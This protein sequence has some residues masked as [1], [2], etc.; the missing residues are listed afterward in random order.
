[1]TI[2]IIRSP[3]LQSIPHGF[4]GRKGGVSTGVYHGLNTGPGSGDDPAAVTENRNRAVAAIAPD[5]Q[6]ITLYQIHSATAIVVDA[7]FEDEARPQGDAMVTNKPGLLLG[8]LTADCTPI[9][10]ADTQNAVIGAAHAG[11]KG[12]IG[13]IITATLDAMESLGAKRENICAAI[14]PTI[15]KSSYEVNDQFR[16]RFL[17]QSPTNERFFTDGKSGHA[18]F[19]LEGYNAASLVEAGVRHIDMLG[20]DTYSAADR[21]YSFRRSTH[22]QESDYGR[23]LSAIALP[24]KA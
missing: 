15:L 1:M 10:F 17:M 22:L 20:L 6:L 3:L 16:E 9:L 12:A 5:C 18:W 8:I 19:D 23:Q 2:D 4:L 21:F 7:P 11:W 14:G 13:G 24:K